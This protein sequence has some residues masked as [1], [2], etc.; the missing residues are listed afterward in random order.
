MVYVFLRTLVLV[1]FLKCILSDKLEME[2][3]VKW[4]TV[5]IVVI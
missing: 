2:L 5:Q 4:K 3:H 1:C